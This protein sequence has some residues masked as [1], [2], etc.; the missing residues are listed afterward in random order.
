MFKGK[1][2]SGKTL[3]NSSKR[4]WIDSLN[5]LTLLHF[6]DFSKSPNPSHNNTSRVIAPQ[7][8]NP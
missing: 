3:F 7:I 4:P 6:N 2:T 1:N 5:Q 8:N